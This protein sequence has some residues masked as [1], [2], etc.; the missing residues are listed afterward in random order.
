M[1]NFL[2]MHKFFKVTLYFETKTE[3]ESVGHLLTSTH[4]FQINKQ[5]KSEFSN[6]ITYPH[7]HSHF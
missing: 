3:R 5:L 2:G 7:T 4:I 6:Q 1:I